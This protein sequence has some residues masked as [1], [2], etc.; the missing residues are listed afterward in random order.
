MKWAKMT[1]NSKTFAL[2]TVFALFFF[3]RFVSLLIGQ[4]GFD[5][6]LKTLLIS[7]VQFVLFLLPRTKSAGV[8]NKTHPRVLKTF[9]SV[10]FFISLS[11]CL[12]FIFPPFE[13]SV[14]S[15]GVARTVLVCLAVPIC[16]ELFF[17]GTL[18]LLL[19]NAGYGKVA[20]FVSALLFAVCHSGLFAFCVSFVMGIL[21]ALYYERTNSLFLPVLCHATNNFISVMTLGERVTLPM[22]L[23]SFAVCLFLVFYKYRGER[24]GYV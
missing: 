16:E 15:F 6:V 8:K 23:I 7:F 20:V 13:T 2:L 9:C 4:S 12:S 21:L 5:T 19:K 3:E 18:F 17:R 10:V 11:V 24:L 1:L 22:F 14:N